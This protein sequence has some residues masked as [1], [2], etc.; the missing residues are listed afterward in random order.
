MYHGEMTCDSEI[1]LETCSVFT[2]LDRRQLKLMLLITIDKRGSKNARNC[3]FG[4]HLSPD[5]FYLCSLIVL[6][7]LTA[8]Y[9]VCLLCPQSIGNLHVD[10]ED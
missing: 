6:P 7:F 8:T 5:Y 3:V 9:P 10:R 4:C 2:T 1:S